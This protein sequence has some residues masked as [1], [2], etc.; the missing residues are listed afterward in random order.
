MKIL[1]Y[2]HSMEL[3]GSQ[4]NAIEIGA[5]VRDLGHEVVIYSEPGPLV[6]RV[7][8]LGLEHIAR[9]ESRLRPGIETVND[10]RRLI[11]NRGFQVLHG[12]EWPPILECQAATHLH[13]SSS[14]GVGTVMSMA[15]APFIPSS[16]PLMVGTALI[17]D[18]V[19]A[20]RRGR[21]EV[22][23]PP[24]DT[25]ANS[26]LI[27]LEMPRGLPA[28]DPD[29]HKVVVV[30]RLVKELKLEGVFTTMRA[31]GVLARSRAVQCVIVG[32]GA[33]A[34]LVSQVADEINSGLQRPAVV[35]AGEC[36]DPRWA[37][38]SADVCIGMGGSAL[39]AMA[40]AQP[41][42]VQGE[43]GFFELLTPQSQARFLHQGWY[44]RADLGP[45]AAVHKLVELLRG[46]LDDPAERETLGTH[47]RELVVARFSLKAAGVQQEQ[48]YR[49]A[50]RA[51]I[52]QHR[53]ASDMARS[54]VG[55]LRYKLGRRVDR[56][57]GRLAVDDFNARPV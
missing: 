20:R 6:E 22:L 31:V 44:G 18:D 53:Q 14:V 38:A 43:G 52:P 54:G 51:R 30:S 19:A 50:R 5:A 2:P 27:R 35:L 11:A 24:V 46:L 12:Y 55:L 3:G 17:Q 25:E 15:V 40:F 23:E 36:M 37:Y 8:E 28:L 57:Q 13:R 56:L 21:V 10:I 7:A 34:H 47:A 16:M 48:F 45:E 32:G 41:L 49:S 42:I 39:R 9:R 29:A 26:P 4:L 33:A 1:V